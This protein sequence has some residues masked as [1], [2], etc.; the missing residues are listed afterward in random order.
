MG[1]ELCVL[2]GRRGPGGRVLW[3]GPMQPFTGG[4][5]KLGPLREA[6]AGGLEFSYFGIAI[7]SKPD[8]S[9]EAGLA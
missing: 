7:P 6:S 9:E 5:I 4:I 2:A 1:G 8:G 3:A